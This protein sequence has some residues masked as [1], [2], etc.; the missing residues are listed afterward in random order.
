MARVPLFAII[1]SP[2]LLLMFVS[3]NCNLRTFLISSV[4]P[5]VFPLPFNLQLSLI[6]YCFVIRITG[7]LSASFTMVNKCSHTVW[8]GILASAGTTPLSTTGFALE[9]DETKTL[10]APASWSGRFWGRTLCSEDSTGKFSC[11]TGDCGSEKIECAG[12]GAAPPATL[13]EF[14]LNGAGGLDFYDV[15]LVDGYNLPMLIVTQG[16]T[17]GNCTVT[18]C[19]ADLNDACP[20]ELKVSSSDGSNS[21]ACKS[22]CEAFGDPQY[23]CSGAYATPDTC[24]SSSYSEFFKHACPR[25]YSYAYDDGTSTFTCAS[26]DYLITFCPSLTTRQKSSDGNPEAADLPLINSTMMYAGGDDVS[27]TASSTGQLIAG[28]VA[29]AAAIWPLCLLF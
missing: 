5:L 8:P 7:T 2:L 23:C 11:V 22:A 9:K 17:G 4:S 15:S 1:L 19:L 26:A 28:S 27:S 16:G 3:G 29:I 20:S 25:A 24:K 14:T 13:A 10:S 21:V 18:G 12:G 6:F